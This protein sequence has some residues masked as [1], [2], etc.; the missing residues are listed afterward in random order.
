MTARSVA[1][2]NRCFQ[3]DGRFY[4]Q[5]WSKVEAAEWEPATFQA[6]EAFV[7]PHS[8]VIDIG[9]WIGPTSLFAAATPAQV[10]AFEPDPAAIDVLRKNLVLNDDLNSRITLEQAAVGTAPGMA[11]LFNDQPG[12]SGSSLV[13]GP[14]PAEHGQPRGFAQVQVIDG[15]AYLECLDMTKVSL[16]KID[17]EGAEYDLIP[18]IAPLL[19]KFRPTLHLSFHPL[20]IGGTGTE[21]EIIRRRHKKTLAVCTCLEHYPHI[22]LETED[23]ARLAELTEPLMDRAGRRPYP[24]GG[25]VFTEKPLIL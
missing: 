2:R 7:E 15:R 24:R 22:Y 9:A 1:I 17:I 5:W 18:H 16:I 8:I 10:H 11:T 21:A 19:A 4:S 25:W 13:G 23:G 3:V 14:N 20:H 6:F 12:N